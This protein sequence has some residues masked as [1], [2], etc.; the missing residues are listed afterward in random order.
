MAGG[1]TNGLPALRWVPLVDV[2]PPLV[3]PI[4]A[5]LAAHRVPAHA[6]AASVRLSTRARRPRRWRLWVD[7]RSWVRA[8][9]IVRTEMTRPS[10]TSPLQ[11]RHL[12]GCAALPSWKWG[13]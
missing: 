5:A 11:R 12:D 7:T 1:V 10:M 6:E 9:D 8:E 13:P 4:L 2:D 3:A